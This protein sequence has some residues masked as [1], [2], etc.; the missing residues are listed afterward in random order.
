MKIL[1]ILFLP[2]SL[3][4]AFGCGSTQPVKEPASEATPPAPSA[5]QR[6][7]TIEE[8]RKS[9]TPADSG[10]ELLAGS[11]ETV[12][13]KG[14]TGELI[15]GIDG[16]LYEQYDAAVIE[17]VQRALKTR[18]LYRGPINGTLD[19]PTMMA[20]HA[21]QEASYG[22][23]RCGVPTPRTRSMLERGSH[24]DPAS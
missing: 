2:V 22:L 10:P 16:E 15:A 7:A 13:A 21:F 23:Q 9:G 4:I 19:A 18:A 14:F 3:T 8:P 17:R 20:I 1:A 11:G 6:A 5:P 12:W 24:T